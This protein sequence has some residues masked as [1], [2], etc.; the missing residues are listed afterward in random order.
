MTFGELRVRCAWRPIP[1]CPGRFVLASGPSRKPPDALVPPSVEVTEHTVAA[2]MDP[3]IVTSLD[4]GGLISYR[5]PDGTFVHT[6]NSREG[7]ERKL[8]QLGLR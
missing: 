5:K 4:E 8:R 3:V 6:L 1:G 7:F 2:A